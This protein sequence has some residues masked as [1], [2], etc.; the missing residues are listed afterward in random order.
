MEP[1]AETKELTVVAMHPGVT[2]EQIADATGW[3][4]KFAAKVAETRAAH[5]PGARGAARPARAHEGGNQAA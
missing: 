4:V 5:R 3:P 2:R 1:D